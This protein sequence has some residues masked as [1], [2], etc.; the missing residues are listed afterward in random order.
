MFY[1]FTELSEEP[2]FVYKSKIIAETDLLNV[3]YQKSDKALQQRRYYLFL[4]H[5]FHLNGNH[6]INFKTESAMLSSRGDFWV[7]E[8]FRI[9]GYNSLRG[10][11][12]QSLFTDFYGYGG[13]EY[14][15]LVNDQA[16]FDVFAQLA[17]VR[18]NIIKKHTQLY[19][20]GAGFN[21]IL[22]IGLMTFQ[23]ANGQESGNPFRFQ[24]TKIHWGIISKF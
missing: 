5:N 24:D 16:Y 18:N 6:Y 7:N 1:D 19:S 2:L 14:R 20:F 13:A 4:E 8:L 10:F 23:I 17:S 12:E 3:A 11:N 15:Y 9:G 21:F 22:P